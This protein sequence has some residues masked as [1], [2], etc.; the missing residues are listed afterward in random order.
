MNASIKSSKNYWKLLKNVFKCKGRTEITPV[1]NVQVGVL[2]IPYNDI[3]YILH[4]F[5]LL[6]MMNQQ[7]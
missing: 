4:Q 7:Y 3:K 2:K 5:H 6:M 1:Q